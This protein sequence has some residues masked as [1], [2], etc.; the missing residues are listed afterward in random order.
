MIP[1]L[2]PYINKRLLPY[3]I[4]EQDVAPSDRR[5]C[6]ADQFAGVNT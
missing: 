1:L 4:F 6:G 5:N 3:N 2:L